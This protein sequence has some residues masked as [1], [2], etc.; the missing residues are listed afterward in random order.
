MTSP[1]VHTRSR[2]STLCRPSPPSTCSMCVA[3]VA[4]CTGRAATTSVSVSSLT[5]SSTSILTMMLTT[6]LSHK[7]RPALSSHSMGWTMMMRMMRMLSMTT[8]VVISW[9][10]AEVGSLKLIEADLPLLLFV[11]VLLIHLSL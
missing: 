3:A 11:F 9:L 7:D 4:K 1:F 5:T 8:V 6:P 2:L 10:K